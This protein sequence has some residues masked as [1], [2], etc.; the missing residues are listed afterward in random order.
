MAIME[1]ITPAAAP[2]TPAGGDA[3]RP[4]GVAQHTARLFAVHAG[5]DDIA[6]LQERLRVAFIKHDGLRTDCYI[7]VV[8]L[9]LLL[10]ADAR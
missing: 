8:L 4:A 3:Q 10:C 6:A 5:E 1:P 2:R 9:Q 7:A